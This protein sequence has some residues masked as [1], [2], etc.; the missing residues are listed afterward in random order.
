MTIELGFVITAKNQTSYALRSIR[1]DLRQLEQSG[2]SV[3]SEMRDT[4]SSLSSLRGAFAGLGGVLAGGM[5]IKG[6]QSVTSGIVSLGSQ[7]LESYANY[8]RL[9]MSLEALV[10]RQLIAS[11]GT[12]KYVQTGTAVLHLSDKEK[13]KLNELQLEYRKLSAEITVQEEH[14]NEATASGRD[15]AAELELRRIRIEENKRE[16]AAMGSEID[17]LQGK[18]GKMVAVTK[19]VV[20]GQMSMQEAM[21]QAGPQAKELLKWIQKLAIQSPFGQEDVAQSFQLA[22]TF[23]YNIDQAKKLTETMVDFAS[24]TGASGDKIG[25]V[26]LV[27]GQ[28]RTLGKVTTQDMNQ[29]SVA[30]IPVREILASAFGVTTQQLQKM[31]EQGLIPADKAIQAITTSL[32][33]D[34]GGAAQRQSETW[35]GLLN[36]LGDLKNIGLREFFSST[37]EAIQPRLAT[38][39]G[40]LTDEKTQ[41]G[42]RKLGDVIGKYLDEKL[43]SA[44]SAVSK[45]NS[46]Y[47][48]TGDVVGTVTKVIA[49]LTGGQATV[50]GTDAIFGADNQMI[51]PAKAQI[52]GIDWT[53]GIEKSGASFTYDT[54]SQVTKVNWTQDPS[55]DAG[56]TYSAES[57][58]TEVHWNEDGFNFAYD[59]K[60]NTGITNVFWGIYTHEYSATTSISSVLWGVYYHVF[61]AGSTVT[62]VAWGAY[63]NEYAATTKISQTGVLWGAWS[64]SYDALAKIG[65]TD[66]LWGAWTNTYDVYAKV[67]EKSILWGLWTNTYDAAGNLTSLTILGKDPTLWLSELSAKWVFPSVPA[68]N[69]EWWPAIPEMASTWWPDVDK[70]ATTWWPDVPK[71]A[72]TWW[73]S[74]SAPDWLNGLLD[75]SPSMPS[76]VATLLSWAGVAAPPP[77]HNAAGTTSFR[78]GLT[79]VGERGPELIMAPRGTRIF[80]NNESMQMA[81]AGGVTVHIH[82]TINNG[83]DVNQLAYQVADIVQRRR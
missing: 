60:S 43:Q 61:D 19:R 6:I 72:S 53:G 48:K 12:E 39:V 22:L 78:G 54:Q 13:E 66:I 17:R 16:L 29:L 36:S 73:P 10:A 15:S 37:F 9:S 58:I 35:Q 55:T 57:G 23:G 67:G 50:K 82:A 2:R 46:E 26:M 40:L 33:R 49:D 44:E 81:G 32:D 3:S 24:A 52:I 68:L 76:W 51:V 8:E 38:F 5:I 63:T 4:G 11:S 64:H 14:L 1:S 7:A 80:N 21:K 20:E 83:L 41:E 69:T 56:F 74:I 34:F 59:Y 45:F 30:G 47:S 27:L 31:V 42:I 62:S 75:W 28:M 25:Q 70:L 18:E 65:Q 79:W 77:D 71:L